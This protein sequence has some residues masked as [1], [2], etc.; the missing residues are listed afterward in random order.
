MLMFIQMLILILMLM[1]MLMHMLM[2]M[3]TTQLGCMDKC[4]V[5]I[6]DTAPVSENYCY[7]YHHQTP[8]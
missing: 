5:E 4:S 8:V 1:L 3:R 7:Y 2:L 6:V